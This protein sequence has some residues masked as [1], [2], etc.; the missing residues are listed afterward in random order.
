MGGILTESPGPLHVFHVLAVVDR[1][2]RS[3]T[4]LFHAFVHTTA[5]THTPAGTLASITVL[6]KSLFT[7]W[8]RKFQA[9]HRSSAHRARSVYQWCLP[10]PET[11]CG[12]PETG[13][14]HRTPTLF[15]TATGFTAFRRP[16]HLCPPAR[17]PP[18]P[19]PAHPQ[20]QPPD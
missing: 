7:S 10:S 13:V 12:L 8:V 16:W 6:G 11:S 15:S 2:E 14:S 20:L 1:V 5:T 4:E 3:C 17:P 9:I 18:P 19:P